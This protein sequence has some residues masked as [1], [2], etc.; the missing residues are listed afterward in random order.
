MMA[1]MKIEGRKRFNKIFVRG[2]KRAYETKNMDSVALYPPV[3]MLCRSFCKP[4]IFAFPIFVRSRK[5]K[6]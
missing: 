5:A 3:D 6:R 1:G 2:S 4:S